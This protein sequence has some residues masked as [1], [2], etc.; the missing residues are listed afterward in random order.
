MNLIDVL[1]QKKV[2]SPPIWIMRQ[3][4]RYLPEF[5]K[6]KKRSK[7]F[8][9]MI[10]NPKVASEV[11]LQPIKRFGFDAAIIFSDI[12][13]IP[14]SLGQSLTYEEGKGPRLKKMT[15]DQ[16]INSFS[17]DRNNKKLSLVYQAIRETKKNLNKNTNLIGF[18][19]APLTVSFFMFDSKREKK[20]SK[21]LSYFKKNKTKSTKLFKILEKASAEYAIGQINAGAQVIQIFDTWAS[22]AKGGDLKF[23]SIDPI[24]RIS[25]LIKEK[26][27]NVPIIVFPR[28]VGSRYGE[29]IQK[30]INCI[31]VGEDI[32]K[33]EIK[34]IQEK[35][36]IQGNLS[37]KIL[38]NG[39]KKMDS[40]IKKILD[41]FSEKP[42]IFNLS[43]GIM[44]GTPV[45]NVKRL[46]EIIRNYKN[47]I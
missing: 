23:F 27:P 17:I 37:P 1:K 33:K 36:T 11:T 46:V 5:R 31:S 42:F 21:I 20:Y 32:K 29:Y 12:L 30:N 4:G 15:L 8:M 2:K 6:L 14:D 47:E 35:K 43:H 45:K 39:G 10:Y 9:N 38:F 18:I 41:Q 13:I 16:M 24:K 26:K 19:G 40:E 28:N 44:P 34:K 7:G 3:A 22:V 25:S